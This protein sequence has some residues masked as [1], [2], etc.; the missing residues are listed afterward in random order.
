MS[1]PI[2]R[3]LTLMLALLFLGAL[4]LSRSYPTIQYVD[5][6]G[7]EHYDA[8]ALARAANLY[9]GRPL[10]WVRQGDVKKI[11]QAPWT[12]K[13]RLVRHFPSSVSLMV[14]EKEPAAIYYPP[15]SQK[16]QAPQAYTLAG[17]ALPDIRPEEARG[18]TEISGWGAERIDEALTLLRLLHSERP[19]VINYTPQGFE[20]QLANATLYTPD[21]SHLQTHWQ[22]FH[23]ALAQTTTTPTAKPTTL[24]AS[25]AV[26]GKALE[27]RQRIVVYSWGI[28]L[29]ADAVNDISQEIQE[30]SMYFQVEAK[31]KDA[32]KR[33]IKNK[34]A[35]VRSLGQGELADS[36]LFITIRVGVQ[37]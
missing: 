28:S 18:L 6:R 16:Q 3:G 23:E 1:R 13:V 25:N 12:A 19:F 34:R 27:K 4:W 24:P 26:L 29:G 8:E 35:S 22:A 17:E 10:L 5:V 7:A 30:G 2:I 9:Q 36:S 15:P 32:R 14:W 20:V 31:P 37:S 21:V 11:A 33:L